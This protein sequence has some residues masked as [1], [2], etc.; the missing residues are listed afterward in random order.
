MLGE[1]TGARS[2]EAD[3]IQAGDLPRLHMSDHKLHLH[4]PSHTKTIS[5]ININ[6]PSLERL[7]KMARSERT[8]W[9]ESSSVNSWKRIKWRMRRSSREF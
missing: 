5:G 7:V 8:R 3:I 1:G 9:I 2:G 6:N 4:L